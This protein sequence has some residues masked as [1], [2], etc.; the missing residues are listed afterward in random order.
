MSK[1]TNLMDNKLNVDEVAD[2]LDGLDGA[3]EKITTLETEVDA[4]GDA[5]TQ[6]NALVGATPLPTGETITH[7][8]ESLN[9]LIGN[10]ALPEGETITHILSELINTTE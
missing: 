3:S 5:I 7:L 4:N 9:E 6:L 1:F 10:T 8:L 2:A